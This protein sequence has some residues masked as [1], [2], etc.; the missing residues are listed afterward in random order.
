MMMKVFHKWFDIA[1]SFSLFLLQYNGV[2]RDDSIVEL[3]EKNPSIAKQF[4][5]NIGS[6]TIQKEEF[7]KKYLPQIFR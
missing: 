2:M 5:Y 6:A 4:Y 3:C 7:V 1:P